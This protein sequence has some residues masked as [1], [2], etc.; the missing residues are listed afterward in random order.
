MVSS[1]ELHAGLKTVKS[2]QQYSKST[3]E[4]L[5]NESNNCNACH[6]HKAVCKQTCESIPWFPFVPHKNRENDNKLTLKIFAVIE[7]NGHETADN[8]RSEK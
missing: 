5:G 2:L 8:K 3:N 1:G 4:Q 6:S 7:I